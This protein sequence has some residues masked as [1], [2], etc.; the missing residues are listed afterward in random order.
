MKLKVEQQADALYLTLSEA[1]A[2]RSEEASPG[3]ILEG[4]LLKF[5]SRAAE[6]CHEAICM[7]TLLRPLCGHADGAGQALGGMARGR[8]F[9][10]ADAG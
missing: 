10:M 4:F 7:V 3:I 1:P 6:Q 9:R 5:A 8:Q 2:T